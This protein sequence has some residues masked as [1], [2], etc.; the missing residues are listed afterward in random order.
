MKWLILVITLL[1]PARAL[2]VTTDS[3]NYLKS[4]PL[5]HWSIL[6]LTAAGQGVVTKDLDFT[7]CSQVMIC[8]KNILVK[9]SLNQKTTKLA[10]ILIE[11]HFQQGQLGQIDLLN[12]DFWGLIALAG[13]GSKKEPIKIIQD[14]ILKNQN[15]D[16]GW[17]FRTGGESDS[18]D[19]AAAIMALSASG[20]KKN[21]PVIQAGVKFI[22]KLKNN[23]GV[24][25]S[26]KYKPDAASTAWALSAFNR[27]GLHDQE[28][29]DSM[30]KYKNLDGSY[31]WAAG[32]EGDVTI[33]SYSLIAVLKK[34][35]P[36]RV[37][38]V[39]KKK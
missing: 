35:Y 37:K 12:D 39:G 36:V 18:N 23:D 1:V 17:G 32:G 11:N 19:T 31:S 4:Q 22:K 25:F 27:I 24:A 16:G 15:I 20:L 3:I 14:H 38:K 21:H 34:S 33:T 28:L 8:A 7:D 6:A 10:K 2:A 26:S 13:E 30:E 5:N 9:L 29:V